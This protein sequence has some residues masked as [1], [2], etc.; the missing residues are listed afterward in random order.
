[1]KKRCKV[2]PWI[3]PRLRTG[4]YTLETEAD[5]IKLVALPATTK[6][7]QGIDNKRKA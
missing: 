3:V 2:V 5:T 4:W 6:K 1:M 7:V